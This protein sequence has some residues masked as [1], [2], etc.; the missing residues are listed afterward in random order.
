MEN[1]SEALFDVGEVIVH[2]LFDYRGVVYDVDPAFN[3]TDE[4]YET[5]ARSRPPKDEPWY[6]VLVD[7][8]VHMT[9]V[10][11]RNLKPDGTD[12]PVVHPMLSDYFSKFDGTAYVPR[13][14]AN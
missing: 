9:Y 6:H 5:M 10:A 11:Q 7:G 12:R 2:R 4:W 14:R 1:T 3:L 8:A 13:D